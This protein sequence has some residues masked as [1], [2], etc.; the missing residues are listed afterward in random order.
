MSAVITEIKSEDKGGQYDSGAQG[1]LIRAP[2]PQIAKASRERQRG[3]PVE[4]QWS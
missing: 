1:R 2:H 3:A 4:R